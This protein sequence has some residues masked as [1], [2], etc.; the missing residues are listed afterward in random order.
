MEEYLQSDYC[1][2]YD[3]PLI[4]NFIK[5]NNIMQLSPV[6]RAVKLFYIV[7]DDIA[8]NMYAAFE[9]DGHA[10]QASTI[11]KKANGW[12]LQ[13]AILLCALARAAEIP[14]RFVMVT[15]KNHKAQE[16]VFKTLGTNIFT[17]HTFNEFYLNGKWVKADATFDKNLCQKAGDPAVEF[18]GVNDALLPPYDLN[19]NRLI[20]YIEYLGTYSSI[21]WQ[22]VIDKSREVYGDYL[23]KQQ[24]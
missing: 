11:L 1:V 4:Q 23:K 9:R 13:K 10:Y 20:E 18:D 7:R 12:C 14:T 21:P 15:M 16:E 3:H 17:P 6:E 5:D 8:Y 2:N 24:A 22:L 19:G